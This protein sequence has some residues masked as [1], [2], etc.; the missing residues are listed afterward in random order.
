MRSSLCMA[1]LVPALYGPAAHAQAPH[2]GKWIS[3][4]IKLI[5]LDKSCAYVEV[6]QGIYELVAGLNH[7]IYGT[8]SRIAQ[9]NIW[10]GDPACTLPGSDH[11][12]GKV[13]FD[14][15]AVN[16][17]YV[18][19]SDQ[20]VDFSYMGCKGNCE[21]DPYASR[22]IKTRI[23]ADGSVL[24]QQA[25]STIVNTTEFRKEITVEQE[26]AEA[27]RAFWQ[28]YKPLAEGSCNQFINQS[29]HAA[30]KSKADMK[31]VCTFSYELAKLLP[32]VLTTEASHS[33]LATNG[34]VQGIFLGPIALSSGDAV[35]ARFLVLRS[36]NFG[37]FAGAVLR[38][39]ADG[40]WKILDIVPM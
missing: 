13:R 3:K 17:T 7:S 36:D 8:F 6:V 4:E 21:T 5:R 16:G 26:E 25:I 22:G 1:V 23:F 27:S 20:D 24:K 31:S 37:I 33:Y 11:P 40:A 14:G 32:G 18:S 35:V 19:P 28:L 29:L 15:W 30:T 12:Q 38:K 2:V 9:Q 10:S 34:N 39:Q